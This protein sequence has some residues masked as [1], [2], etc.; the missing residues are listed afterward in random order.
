MGKCLLSID[1]DYFIYIKNDNKGINGSYLE[2][3]R[4]LVDLCRAVYLFDAHADLGY[5]GLSSLN[6]EVDCSNW[7]GKLFKDELIEEATIVY[8]PVHF[9]KTRVFQSD[10]QNLQHQILRF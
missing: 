1:W 6:F 10:E 2:N 5:G 9:R 4:G 8:M 7:L 3:D